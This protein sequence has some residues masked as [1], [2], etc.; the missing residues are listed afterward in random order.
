MTSKVIQL[1]V[2]HI[3]GDWQRTLPILLDEVAVDEHATIRFHHVT[4]LIELD[5]DGEMFIVH[6]KAFIHA[7]RRAMIPGGLASILPTELLR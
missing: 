1:G 5:V 7:I 6:P 4:G 3:D 2:A